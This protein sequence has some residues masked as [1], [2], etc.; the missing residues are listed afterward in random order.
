MVGSLVQSRQLTTT[1]LQRFSIT[2]RRVQ[3]H[4]ER[5]AAWEHLVVDALACSRQLTTTRLSL[6]PQQPAILPRTCDV[7]S[8]PI[9]GALD[10]SAPSRTM[11]TLSS[12]PQ[13]PAFHPH[14]CCFSSSPIT[15]ALDSSAPSRTMLTLSSAPMA[16]KGMMVAPKRQAMRTNSA[17]LGHSSA[18][19]SPRRF[20]A[21]RGDDQG[22]SQLTTWGRGQSHWGAG[23]AMFGARWMGCVLVTA[24][25]HCLR[26]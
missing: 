7:S 21:C 11:L 6:Q 15:G 10:S 18:Y 1:R 4:S 2:A 13:Q 25:L 5:A 19:F 20:I 8:S 24:P 22:F 12:Q 3:E 9:T 23:V 14:T 16:A 17:F 26:G